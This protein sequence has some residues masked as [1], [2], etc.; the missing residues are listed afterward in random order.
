MCFMICV[1]AGWRMGMFVATIPRVIVWI[2][3]VIFLCIDFG[4]HV[5]HRRC[6]S[7]S[8]VDSCLSCRGKCIVR[9]SFSLEVAAWKTQSFN[10]QGMMWVWS[11]SNRFVLDDGRVIVWDFD[12]FV[13]ESGEECRTV[14]ISVPDYLRSQH[15]MKNMSKHWFIKVWDGGLFKQVVEW[16]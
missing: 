8:Q 13:K 6:F 10:S 4:G 12:G 1:M 5:L 15:L 16:N 3:K 11:G 2:V 14:K 9:C 7:S